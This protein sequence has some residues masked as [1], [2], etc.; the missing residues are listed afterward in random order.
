MPQSGG[1]NSPWNR[2]R[3]IFSEWLRPTST[4]NGDG[5]QAVLSESHSRV[6]AKGIAS[7]PQSCIDASEVSASIRSI[8]IHIC[9]KTIGWSIGFLKDL[10]C[11]A[12]GRRRPAVRG[13]GLLTR[14]VMN[15]CLLSKTR[16]TG[17][18]L[19]WSMGSAVGVWSE[20][21]SH[22]IMG[23]TNLAIRSQPPC[24]ADVTTRRTTP[25]IATLTRSESIPSG[26]F[27]NEP[28]GSIA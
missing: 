24:D 20:Q 4:R 27:L 10:C 21:S 19:G 13:L 3:S 5:R 25:R 26:S 12:S 7:R 22:H 16:S 15:K 11:G 23:S 8:A 28:S 9:V 6:A 18:T 17:L 1:T 2:L 14:G